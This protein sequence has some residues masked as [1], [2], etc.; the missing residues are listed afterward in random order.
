MATHCR[1]SL[2]PWRPSFEE[3][4]GSQFA[5]QSLSHV[6]LLGAQ[7]LSTPGSFGCRPSSPGVTLEVGTQ[8]LDTSQQTPHGAGLS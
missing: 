6:R 5:V 2:A 1:L 3:A 7:R 4:G 8:P